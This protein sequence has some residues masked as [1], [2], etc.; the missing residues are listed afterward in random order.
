MPEILDRSGHDPGTT[1]GT[2]DEVEGRVGKMLNDGGGNGRKWTFSGTNVVGRGW[3]VAKRV[4][5]PGDGKVIHFVV[6][7]HSRFGNHEV[8]AKKE[9]DRRRQTDCHT[10]SI[11]RHDMR[12]SRSAF[13]LDHLQRKKGAN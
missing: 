6:A 5:R 10:G 4:G 8:R 2:H 7:N 11:R 13:R 12:C 9:I 1:G 3:N